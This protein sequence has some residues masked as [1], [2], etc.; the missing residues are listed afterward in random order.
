MIHQ[1]SKWHQN[2]GY[3]HKITPKSRPET[4]CF[5]KTC[6]FHNQVMTDKI[7]K[8]SPVGIIKYILKDMFSIANLLQ[9]ILFDNS[10][11][12]FSHKILES[13]LFTL[14]MQFQRFFFARFYAF[15]PFFE[16]DFVLLPLKI[17]SLHQI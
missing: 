13:V 12:A 2:G 15:P 4:P 8:K 6:P 16:T 3:V 9:L 14:H 17:P 10:A 1:I 11:H 5:S 7:G